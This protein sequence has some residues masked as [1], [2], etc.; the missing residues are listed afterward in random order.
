MCKIYFH[1]ISICIPANIKGSTSKE[2][3]IPICLSDVAI[4]REIVLNKIDQFN[5]S[6]IKLLFFRL[7]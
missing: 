7:Y 1:N 4:Q 6:E 2:D 3:G 5:F